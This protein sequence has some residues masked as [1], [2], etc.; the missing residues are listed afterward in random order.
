MTLPSTCS[1]SDKIITVT[2]AVLATTMY[3]PVPVTGRIKEFSTCL[4]AALTG[5]DETFTLSYAPPGSTTYTAVTGGAVVIASERSAAGDVDSVTPSIGTTAAVTAGG[6]IKIVPSG[7]GG[8][9]VPVIS[10]IRIG[11]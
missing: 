1:G 9:A 5:A 10:T 8:G 7:G 11:N 2:H 4:G 6:S 3:V